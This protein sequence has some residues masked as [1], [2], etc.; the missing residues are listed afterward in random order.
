MK[1][2]PL[3]LSLFAIFSLVSCS[4]SGNN[5]GN[6]GGCDPDDMFCDNNNK[7]DETKVELKDDTNPNYVFDKN[8]DN[9]NASVN[10]EIFV[11]SFYDSNGDGTGDLNGVDFKLDYLKDLGVKNLW[12]MPINPSPSYHGY[13]I[14]DYYKIH[15]SFGTLDDF[16][17][18]VKDAK[19]RNMG[20]LIDLV[21]NH[22]STKNEWFI[23]SAKDY[24][25]NNTEKGSKKDWYNWSDK[26]LS[27]YASYSYNGKTAYYEARF[28][29]GMPD[30][31]LDNEEVRNEIKNIC[32]FYLDMGV[33]GFRLDACLYYYTG[34]NAK[35]IEFLSWLK[36]TCN[37]I[38][39]S[40]YIVGE[41]W[42]DQKTIESY[43]SSGIDSFFFFP[44]SNNGTGNGSIISM[45]K[46]L[47]NASS[48]GAYIE[49][50]EKSIKE[51]NPKARNSY[52]LSNHDTDRISNN[53]YGI[54][55]KIGAN[56]TYLLPGTPFMYYGEEIG[57]RGVRKENDQ[58]DARR[59][60]PMIWSKT[61]KTG[62][63]K[64]PEA[65]R[66]DLNNTAQVDTGVSDLLNENYSLV[67]HYK[68]VLNVRNKYSF[69]ENA[70][71][72][73][74]SS[75]V[76]KENPKV[77]VYEL[78]DE[79]NKII[80]VHNCSDSNAKITLKSNDKNLNTKILDS[81]NTTK[82]VPEFNDGTLK[83]GAKS[84]VILDVND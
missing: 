84:T 61:D 42:S 62:E 10:Y 34:N 82:K 8:V 83:I 74:L 33:A 52:F 70:S 23:Q 19:D 55:A 18:L 2:N 5:N 45:A 57:L 41:T 63:C 47:T 54:N 81:I 72:K 53:L 35:N 12:L 6:N 15:P 17:K 26:S 65:H 30:L 75:I 56:I 21:L 78:F 58:S 7:E 9:K 16:K 49:D 44:S 37:E 28:D 27:G 64:F 60:L 22:S 50:T 79:N 11:R 68:K 38:N 13:D 51:N 73:D 43:Y 59:R 29:S 39:P 40:S 36:K 67:N 69:I 1:R 25:N 32:K 77:L 46:C 71:F 20:I 48:F 3:I 80:V 14:S 24:F 66:Q 76:F 4:G 31:N